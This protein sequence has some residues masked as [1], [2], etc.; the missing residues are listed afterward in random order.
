MES[1]ISK[2]PRKPER[3]GTPQKRLTAFDHALIKAARDKI[4]VTLEIG[5]GMKVS[6]CIVKT[7][8]MYALEIVED[9]QPGSIWYNKSFI[10]SAEIHDE[11]SS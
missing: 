9:E 5:M 4:P 10:V 11:A 8:D 1:S 6:R 3:R 7:V 2:A